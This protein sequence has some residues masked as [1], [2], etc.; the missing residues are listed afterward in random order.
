MSEICKKS[1]LHHNASVLTHAVG[2]GELD[3]TPSVRSG[4]QRGRP[5]AR[6]RREN[7]DALTGSDAH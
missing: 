3:E 1:R 4:F 6:W 7:G 5:Q 2:E